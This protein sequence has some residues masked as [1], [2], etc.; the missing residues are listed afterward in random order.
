MSTVQS[1]TKKISILTVLTAVIAGLVLSGS[2]RVPLPADA[3]SSAQIRAETDKLEK[4]IAQKKAVVTDISAK[5]NTL[6]NKIAGIKAEIDRLD[7]EIK[8]INIKIAQLQEELKQTQEDLAH[9]KAILSQSLREDYKFGELT[10]IEVFASSESFSDFF[11]Q[12]EYLTR[13]RDGVHESSRK[14][15]ELEQQLIQQEQEQRDLKAE[16]T[17][18]RKIQ[19][20][21]RAEEQQILNQ[22]KGDEAAYRKLIENLYNQYEA[23]EEALAEA[24]RKEQYS[25]A[26]PGG[27]G[28]GMLVQPGEIVTKG[29]TIAFVG[30]T[31]F[32]TGPHLH[33]SL[34][35]A[36]QYTE[37][38]A[39]P[40]MYN[41]PLRLN[42]AWPVPGYYRLSTPY[43]NVSCNN[44]PCS[45]SSKYH[46]GIDIPAPFYTPIVAARAGVIIYSGNTGGSYGNLV[47][48]DH[49]DGY[50]TYYGHISTK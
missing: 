22:T 47:V 46:T 50:K 6:E 42:M 10:T 43:G 30:S 49:G 32:S 14:V 2:F 25:A 18:K 45:G 37:P 26:T 8:L 5:V 33:F 13:V 24:I 1:K 41:P 4:E 15:A 36:G 29:Q 34:M 40:T 48:I 28:R 44:Y 27:S 19:D 17:G 23:A 39:Q 9:Q 38:R 31:G 16:L 12:Q 7:S 20:Q 3:K 21:Q 11:N 35:Y